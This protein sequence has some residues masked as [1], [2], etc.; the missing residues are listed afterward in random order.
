[1]FLAK[2]PLVVVAL[3]AGQLVLRESRERAPSR[4]DAVGALASVAGIGLLVWTTIEAPGHGWTSAATVAGYAGAVLALAGFVVWELRRPE[5]LLDVR[6]FT[7]PRVSAGSGAIALAFFAL[8]GFIFLITQYFQAVLGYGPLAAG[9]RTLPFALVIGADRTAGDHG[10]AGV[11]HQARRGD[12][13]AGDGRGL[14]RGGRLGRGLGVLGPHRDL[15]VLMA[16]VSGW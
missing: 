7:D 1:M 5:P 15:M 2:L 13:S 16:E 6:L 3:V 10:D 12:R 11:R 9:L 14:R 4:F 8:F